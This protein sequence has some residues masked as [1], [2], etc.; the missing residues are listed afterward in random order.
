MFLFNALTVIFP[1]NCKEWIKYVFHGCELASEVHPPLISRNIN[2]CLSI[3]KMPKLQTSKLV[4][5]IIP[6]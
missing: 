3:E 6:T 4:L 2:L 1:S 5:R